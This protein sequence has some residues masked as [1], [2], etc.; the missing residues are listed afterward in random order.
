MRKLSNR[1]FALVLALVTALSCMALASAADITEDVE[2]PLF[3]A[4]SP[5]DVVVVLQ[6]NTID[7]NYKKNFSATNINLTS[8]KYFVVVAGARSKIYFTI[9]NR[10]NNRDFKWVLEN[11]TGATVT[12]TFYYD[13]GSF[14]LGLYDVYATVEN[15]NDTYAFQVMTTDYPH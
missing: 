6:G 8:R 7:S 15:P 14:P 2:S 11:T 9:H 1:V 12:H 4:V 13:G 10:L 3:E 5:R